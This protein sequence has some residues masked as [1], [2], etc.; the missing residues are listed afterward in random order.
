MDDLAHD[1]VRA[2]IARTRVAEM[3]SRGWRVL[4][5]GEEGSLLMEGPMLA[6]RAAVLDAPIGGLFD[7]LIARALERADARDRIAARRAA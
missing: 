6:G 5:P 3:K 7:D 4:G 1:H 2:F